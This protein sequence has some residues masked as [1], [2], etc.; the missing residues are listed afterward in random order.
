MTYSFS[1]GAGQ[2]SGINI[3]LSTSIAQALSVTITGG[4][5]NVLYSNS[6]IYFITHSGPGTQPSTVVISGSDVDSTVI[7]QA[8]DVSVPL[9]DFGITD[10]T[11]ALETNEIYQLSFISSTP[12]QDVTLG[13]PTEIT[14]TDDDGELNQNKIIKNWKSLLFIVVTV[15]FGSLTYSFSEGA[16]QSSGINISLSTSIAQA[17][18]VTITGGI[19]NVLYSNSNIYFITHSGPGTQPS[20]VVISGSDVDSTVI[21]QA[22]DVSVPLPNFG[23]TDDTT[24]LE[25]NEIYQLSF[26][27]STPSQDVTLG[28][29][30]EITITDDDGELNQNKIIKNWKSLLF[31]VVT[32]NFGSLTYSFSEGAGQSSGINISLSTSIAQALSVTITGGIYNVLYSNFNKIL[33]HIQDLEHNLQ[34]LLYLEVM[35]TQQ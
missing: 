2:S 3:A 7:F 16:G 21:F 19:Y 33:L 26:I 1:E 9:P 31:I 8:G 14:I 27:S 4:I 5:Y 24:A 17:L 28:V 32:V 10:D 30:T 29:P 25:T 22:G 35:W 12:S 6:N 13:V 18:S 23:I 20:T 15:S 34:P 11:T